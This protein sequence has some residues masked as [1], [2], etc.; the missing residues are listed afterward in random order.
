MRLDSKRDP[1]A[2]EAGRAR[3]LRR[4]NGGAQPRGIRRTAR[5]DQPKL[6]ITCTVNQGKAATIEPERG[7][8]EIAPVGDRSQRL[9]AWR[10]AAP[11]TEC[12]PKIA[13]GGNRARRPGIMCRRRREVHWIKRRRARKFQAQVIE[14]RPRRVNDHFELLGGRPSA[15]TLYALAVLARR[16][17]GMLIVVRLRS[18]SQWPTAA[19][20]RLMLCIP[21]SRRKD[22]CCEPCHRA[23]ARGRPR[24]R[25]QHHVSS[26]QPAGHVSYF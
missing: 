20:E 1:P 9:A 26:E 5:V 6:T 8:S 22:D 14:P 24:E 2:C 16:N 11:R 25:Q 4:T 17:R 18:S 21:A 23:A 15:E 12:D 3:L 7:L 13:T 19:R 10:L